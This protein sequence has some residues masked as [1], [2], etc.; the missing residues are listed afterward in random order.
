MYRR[1][2][3]TADDEVAL[4]FAADD[5]RPQSEPLVN[6]RFALSAA[7]RGGVITDAERRTL[8]RLARAAYFPERS[9]PRL[10]E[11]ASPFLA[12]DVIQK[13]A[14]FIDAGDFNLKRR[15]ALR[16]LVAARRML[17]RAAHE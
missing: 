3:L 13:I 2:Q 10:W 12:P 1:R 8:L 11:D 4:V 15:D 7:R 16:L 9:W 6:M 17:D 14:M 5:F